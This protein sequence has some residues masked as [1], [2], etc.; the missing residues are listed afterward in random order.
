MWLED[1]LRFHFHVSHNNCALRRVLY[2][3]L[4][5][6]AAGISVTGPA[7]RLTED[8]M[9]QIATDVIAAVELISVSLGSGR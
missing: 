1:D 4:C 7:H 2:N 5:E 3:E 6:V 8:V 9:R